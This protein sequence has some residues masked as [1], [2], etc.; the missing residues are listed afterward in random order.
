MS[1]RAI[2]LIAIAFILYNVI[3]LAFGPDSLYAAILPEIRMLSGGVWKFTFG[4]LIIL[5]SVAAVAIGRGRAWVGGRLL[6]GVEALASAELKPVTL[7]WMRGSS[8]STRSQQRCAAATDRFAFPFHQ[9]IRDIEESFMKE[10][11]NGGAHTSAHLGRW[12]L[13]NSVS[14]GRSLVWLQCPEDSAQ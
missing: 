9:V 12:R 1:L 6:P 2:P 3:V 13:G 8:S 5:M 4:D 11:R 7:S 10:T 14:P